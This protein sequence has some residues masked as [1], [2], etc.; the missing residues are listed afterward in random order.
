MRISLLEL[1]HW[2][3]I[4]CKTNEQSE[5]NTNLATETGTKQERILTVTVRIIRV[6][7]DLT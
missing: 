7:Y 2:Q 1:A 6:T 3:D 4:L 5:Q